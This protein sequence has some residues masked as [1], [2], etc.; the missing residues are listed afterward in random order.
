MFLFGISAFSIPAI[1]AA[2]I[3]DML[4][5]TEAGKAFG[6]V[7]F[8][9]G[10]GQIAGPTFAGYLAESTQSFTSSYLLAALLTATAIGLTAML[11]SN[12]PSENV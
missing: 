8:F 12:H 2:T 11:A 9:F 6:L 4:P 7:T 10:I 3:S 5:A 1:I